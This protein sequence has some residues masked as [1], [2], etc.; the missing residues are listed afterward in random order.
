MKRTPICLTKFGCIRP[1]ASIPDC[2]TIAPLGLRSSRVWTSLYG[3][4]IV[5]TLKFGFLQPDP[6]SVRVS[7]TRVAPNVRNRPLA[8]DALGRGFGDHV[9]VRVR[10][11][12]PLRFPRSEPSKCYRIAAKRLARGRWSSLTFFVISL[13]RPLFH[14][15]PLPF[16]VVE[17]ASRADRNLGGS[18]RTPSDTLTKDTITGGIPDRDSERITEHC[19]CISHC[20]SSNRRTGASSVCWFLLPATRVPLS[21]SSLLMLLHALRWTTASEASMV[22]EDFAM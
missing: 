4:R 16:T 14:I 22:S 8:W 15:W 10:S 21:Q 17:I 6:P 18:V 19:G 20:V 1:S 13:A 12:R 2:S 5:I 7:P 3:R 9:A 11:S